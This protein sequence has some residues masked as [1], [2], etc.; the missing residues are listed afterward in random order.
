MNGYMMIVMGAAV[1]FNFIVILIKFQRKRVL[2]A[3]IDTGILVLVGQYLSG[4]FAGLMVGTIASA[5]SS[6][7]LWFKPP[8]FD[9]FKSTNTEPEDIIEK[10]CNQIN[11]IIDGELNKKTRRI[12]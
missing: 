8:T 11:K 12:K 3:L 7:Y 5:I 6:V 10:S 4:S 9:Q 1:S 2:D